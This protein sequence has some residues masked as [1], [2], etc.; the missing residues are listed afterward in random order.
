MAE[1]IAIREGKIVAVGSDKE[2]AAYQGAATKIIDAKKHMVLP[3]FVDAH[4]HILAGGK[5]VYRDPSWEIN[6]SD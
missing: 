4:V 2:I 1:A 5:V 6:S 3:G